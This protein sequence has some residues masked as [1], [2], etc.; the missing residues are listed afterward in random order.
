MPGA[1]RTTDTV[2]ATDTHILLVPSPGG[3]VPT[4]TP[5]PFNGSLVTAVSPDVIIDGLGAATAGSEARNTPPHIAPPPATFQVPPTNKGTVQQGSATVLINGKPAAR[6]G[7][8]VITCNDPSPLP[9]GRITSGS[10]T[11]M[12]G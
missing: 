2:V 6:L 8:T 9:I 12:I 5:M 3:P 4:P 10:V 7:D 1:A 11:V